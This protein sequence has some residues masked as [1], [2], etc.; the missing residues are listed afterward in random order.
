MSA[1]ASVFQVERANL[2]RR[3]V[4]REILTGILPIYILGGVERVAG[5]EAD[6]IYTPARNLQVV[7]SYTYNWERQTVAS[8]GDVRPVGVPHENVPEQ[9]AHIRGKVPFTESAPK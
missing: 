7:G 9:T 5:F 6:V 4:P 1:T 2:P 8:T 3:D